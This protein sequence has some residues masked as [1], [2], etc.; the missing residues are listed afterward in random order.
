MCQVAQ[1]SV[2]ETL[3]IWNGPKQTI[4][5]VPTQNELNFT[6]LQTTTADHDRITSY[7]LYKYIA[8]QVTMAVKLTFTNTY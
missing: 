1:L 6:R 5:I 2:S 3:A 8:D 4:G 7:T